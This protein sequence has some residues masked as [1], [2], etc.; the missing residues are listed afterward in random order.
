MK[1][2]VKKIICMLMMAITVLSTSLV[3]AQNALEPIVV[4]GTDVEPRTDILEWRYKVMDG[5]FYKR[6]YNRSTGEWETDWILV[7]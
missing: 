3:Y 7:Q 2:K 1:S 5:H 6:L 4:E